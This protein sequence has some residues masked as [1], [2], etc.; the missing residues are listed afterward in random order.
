[1]YSLYELISL[2]RHGKEND[3]ATDNMAA[4]IVYPE[5]IYSCR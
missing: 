1:M 3:F 4:M 5:H 2:L